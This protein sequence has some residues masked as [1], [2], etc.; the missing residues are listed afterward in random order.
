MTRVLITGMCGFLGHHVAEHLLRTTDWELVA[1]DRLDTSGNLNRLTDLEC[2]EREK[3]RVKI[4]WHDLKAPISQSI[5]QRIGHVD[6]I[7]HLA[8]STHVDRS[9]SDPMSFVM[10]NVVG[11][12]NLLE[13]ARTLPTLH[14][15]VYFST[16]EVFGPS[17]GQYY[18]E[19]D[20]HRAGNPYS[21]TK[22]GAEQLCWSYQ[23]TYQLPICV[24][25][26][27]NLIGP[28]QHAEKFVPSTIKKILA[29]EEVIIHADPT[30]TIPGARSYIHAANVSAALLFLLDRAAIG[31]V[32]HVIGEK[33]VDN[34]EMAE[35][36]SRQLNVPLKFRLVDFHS[37]RPGHDRLYRLD[38]SRM[39]EMGWKIP[40]P[41][42]DSLRETIK[43]YTEH[44][45][46]L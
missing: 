46:W 16:D 2:W 42:E 30:C 32:Y 24:A 19:W 18:Q 12:C 11:T 23:N 26:G 7:F 22:S 20:R 8:A 39:H 3:R 15:F 6:T 14:R 38:G 28:R 34:L 21:A 13:Y 17:E 29:N 35:L 40:I 37:S 43:W 36:I 9:I 41:F 44:P 25:R 10:D 5:A 31:E 33:E 4:V 27:M 1:L 45:E